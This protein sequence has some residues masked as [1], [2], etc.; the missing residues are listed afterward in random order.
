ML[1][2]HS[3]I[4]PPQFQK[5]QIG[6]VRGIV[7]NKIGP[8]VIKCLNFHLQGVGISTF[9]KITKKSQIITVLCMDSSLCVYGKDEDFK[10]ILM[11]PF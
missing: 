10:E 6:H 4:D 7:K 8:I 5:N 3:G 9:S 2:Y 11:S 1:P